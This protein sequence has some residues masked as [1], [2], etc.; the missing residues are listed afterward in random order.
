MKDEIKQPVALNKIATYLEGVPEAHLR[1]VQILNALRFTT[2]QV[3]ELLRDL[4]EYFASERWAGPL[5]VDMMTKRINASL[6]DAPTPARVPV[7]PGSTVSQSG[8]EQGAMPPTPERIFDS[9]ELCPRCG[10]P[11]N[12]HT[13]SRPEGCIVEP[14]KEYKHWPWCNG[15]RRL[16]AGEPG[17]ACCCFNVKA[18]KALQT[19][20]E[21]CQPAESKSAEELRCEDCGKLIINPEQVCLCHTS[22]P[23]VPRDPLDDNYQTWLAAQPPAES[24]SAEALA[25][26]FLREYFCPLVSLEDYSKFVDSEKYSGTGSLIVTWGMKKRLEQPLAALLE[27]VREAQRK[28][29]ANIVSEELGDWGGLERKVLTE[30]MQTI[31]SAIRRVGAQVS[32]VAKADSKALTEALESVSKLSARL[33]LLLD[34]TDRAPKIVQSTDVELD[35]I[36]CK[37]KL[38]MLDWILT[39]KDLGD[40]SLETAKNVKLKLLEELK[41]LERVKEK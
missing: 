6:A 15:D 29:D 16:P 8:P 25:R 27:R 31:A 22:R 7:S 32:V 4:P 20:L 2:E 5:V 13:H 37:A 17:H 10:E 12:R 14:P 24:K 1:A 28:A 38:E 36:R 26:E 23:P 11:L 35:I 3:R 21:Q 34:V 18:E 41:S 9:P 33:K 40:I 39:E 19:I 30:R